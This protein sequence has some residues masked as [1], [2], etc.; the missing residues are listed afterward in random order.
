MFAWLF[1]KI[2]EIGRILGDEYDVSA[3]K[4][5]RDLLELFSELAN[6][7]LVDAIA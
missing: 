3:E 4:L 1:G 7:N 5:E 6:E 2:S